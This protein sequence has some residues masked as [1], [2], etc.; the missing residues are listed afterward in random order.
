MKNKNQLNLI[1]KKIIKRDNQ[2]YQILD[3]LNKNLKDKNIIF[4]LSLKDSEHM[5]ISIYYF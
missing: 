1:G 2:M 3:F 5:E 4:G